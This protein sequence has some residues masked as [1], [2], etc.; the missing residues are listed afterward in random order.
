M[1]RATIRCAR[2]S[3]DLG[4]DNPQASRAGPTRRPPRARSAPAGAP[5]RSSEARGN[6]V[7]LFLALA[8]S[9]PASAAGCRSCALRDRWCAPAA[10]PR[11]ARRCRGSRPR[12]GLARCDTAWSSAA[13]SS[14]MSSRRP[15]R[16]RSSAP[17]R[18]CAWSPTRRHGATREKGM[19][20]RSPNDV[21]AA[22]ALTEQRRRER[23]RAA[24][25]DHFERAWGHRGLRRPGADRRRP[26]ASASRLSAAVGTSRQGA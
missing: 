25:Q 18:S 22:L 24:E 21:R 4:G 26:R 1:A 7:C 20:R 11:P 19:N 9:A 14:A 23:I 8:P 16:G 3:C 2:N 12:R 10:P 13:T 15:R 17:I 5:R 6:A